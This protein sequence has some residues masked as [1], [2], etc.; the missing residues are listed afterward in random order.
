M[1]VQLSPNGKWLYGDTT[2]QGGIAAVLANT[3]I[4]VRE[5]LVGVAAP[6]GTHVTTSQGVSTLFAGQQAMAIYN[7]IKDVTIVVV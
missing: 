4:A 1:A 6:L 3:V 7:L 5:E 2:Q